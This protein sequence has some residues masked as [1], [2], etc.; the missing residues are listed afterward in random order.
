MLV[1]A[2]VVRDLAT[3]HSAAGQSAMMCYDAAFKTVGISGSF[4]TSARRK[5]L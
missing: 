5:V 4:G 3:A 1:D 2:L